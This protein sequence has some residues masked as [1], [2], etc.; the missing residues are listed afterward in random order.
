MNKKIT[1][2]AAVA[3]LSFSAAFAQV[4]RLVLVEEFTQ[5]SCPPCASQN[6]AFNALLGP[7]LGVKVAAIKYQ[8][9]W[10]GVDPMN[11]QTQTW[12]GPRVT[13]YAVNGVPDAIMDGNVLQGAPSSVTQ[14][15]ID[16]RYAV[17]S[18]FS[19]ALTHTMSPDF[20]SVYIS[21]NI[22]AAQAFTSNGALKL[23]V[24]LVEKE[25]NFSSPP[26]SNGEMLFH[27]VM[28]QMIPNASGT[29]LAGTWANADNASYTFAVAKPSYI[30]DVNQ[31]HVVAFI[32]SDGNKEVHQAALTNPIPLPNDAQPTAV[33]GLPSA[34]LACSA[35]TFTPSVTIKNTGANTLTSLDINVSVASVAQPV[36][37]WT[38]SLAS[39]ATAV[40][41]LPAVTYNGASGNVPV[42]IS[43]ANPNATVDV[44]TTNDSRNSTFL[45]Y[46]GTAQ[47]S[48]Y[49]QGFTATAFPPGI[50]G[51]INAD[52]DTYTWTRSNAG[53]FAQGVGSARLN[54]YN[55]AAGTVDDMVLGN[56][57]MTTAS[58]ASMTFSVAYRQYSS[59]NDQL[60]VMVST[61]CGATWTTVY[62][63]QGS[64]LATLAASQSSFTPNAASQWRSETVSLSNFATATN[65]MIKFV[66][67]S[68]YGNNLYVDDINIGTVGVEEAALAGVGLHIFPNPFDA[69]ATV[70]LN[71]EQT[72][73]ITVEVYSLDGKLVLAEN[74]GEMTAGQH[75]IAL[76]GTTLAD[77]MYFVTIRTGN[78]GTITRK[79]TVAH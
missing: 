76:D 26:G 58:V 41:T 59:E 50:I 5:A 1:L 75:N 39:G 38:G 13:Y 77:G 61:D 19:L 49:Q 52:N 30:Y 43:T 12:V 66:G 42:S 36:Y 71:L 6:P 16:T 27:D 79:V 55:A 23:H 10:P 8:T 4:Q 15:G 28:R 70:Q 47:T 73:N 65:L 40:V 22:T 63:K 3:G 62:D 69:S 46:G 68:D 37:N 67:T 51:I 24:A 53:G 20:D 78:N 64:V 54:F 31:L 48:P 32:Q 74:K 11:T 57:N 2:L 17:G 29:T 9:N 56:F 21:V 25:I 44:N 14:A 72:E 35:V 60:Q 18:P 34:G 33:A 7:N 45:Y